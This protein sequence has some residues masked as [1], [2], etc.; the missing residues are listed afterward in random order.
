MCITH[1]F[2]IARHFYAWQYTRD[3]HTDRHPGK[4]ASSIVLLYIFFLHKYF[5]ALIAFIEV[6]ATMIAPLV[7]VCVLLASE[8][9]CFTLFLAFLYPFLSHV[10]IFITVPYMKHAFSLNFMLLMLCWMQK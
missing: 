8:G 10:H 5:S 6:A 7:C 4:H 1:I 2:A 3:L 9:Y